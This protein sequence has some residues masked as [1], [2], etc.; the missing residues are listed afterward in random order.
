MSSS[1]WHSHQAMSS[2]NMGEERP[3]QFQESKRKCLTGLRQ[4]EACSRTRLGLLRVGL[5]NRPRE[6]AVCQRPRYHV[7]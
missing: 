4:Q 1:A 7:P 6:A 2:W 3:L 5:G